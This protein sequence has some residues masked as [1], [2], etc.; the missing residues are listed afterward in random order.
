MLKI[1][2]QHIH[3]RYGQEDILSDVNLVLDQPSSTALL[4]INGSGKST[5]LQLIAGFVL[6]TKGKLVYTEDTKTIEP[7]QHY[8]YISYCA[9]YLEI[10][11]EMN[12]T[13][14]LSYHFSFKKPHLS[15]ADMISYIGLE[16]AKHKLIDHYSSG[17]KQR[18]KLAQ[19]LFADTPIVLLDEPCTNLDSQGIALYQRMIT[20]FCSNKIL[21]VASNDPN[22]Y[23]VCKNHIQMN[24]FKL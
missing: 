10:I 7:D 14:Y 15:I 11:E 2:L 22:E 21:L 13:E 12:L 24:Q 18:V 4:G 1:E 5:L 8:Q 6:P 16:H 19:A 9:P 3:K 20:D 17:M 23:Q